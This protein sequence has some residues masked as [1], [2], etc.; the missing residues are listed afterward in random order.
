MAQR[1]LRR[2]AVEALCSGR[3]AWIAIV[4]ADDACVLG[5]T[6][7]AIASIEG[8]LQRNG[9]QT[10]ALRVGVASHTPLLRAAVE[11]F[12]K[13]LDSSALRT[14]VQAVIAGIDA[15]PVMTRER[16]VDTLAAQLATTIEWAQCLDTLHERGCRVFLELGPGRALSGMALDRLEDVQA[17]S[18][19]EF[20]DPAAIPGWVDRALQR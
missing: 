17:R 12:R 4:T 1:G 16:A 3:D 8:D 7:E 9:A 11:P 5:G 14:P 6:S 18:V 10:T 19:D 15:A 13:L 20:G 2:H